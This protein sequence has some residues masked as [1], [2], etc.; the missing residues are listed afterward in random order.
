VL[1]LPEQND[2]LH[3]RYRGFHTLVLEPRRAIWEGALK[4]SS[5]RYTIR[6][7]YELPPH[8]VLNATTLHY[9]PRVYVL[10]PELEE[11]PNYELGP[12]PHVWWGRRYRGQPNLCLFRPSKN[13]WFWDSPLD[14]TTIPDACEWLLFYEYWLATRRWLGG[15]EHAGDPLKS[16]DNAK[17]L[18]R[19]ALS[20]AAEAALAAA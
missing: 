12:I 14:E 9:Y 8:F 18:R 2:R 4:P 6:I 17:T 1:W 19:D 3:A 16:N 10:E 11:H 7:D 5:Q 15:G 20:G 13:E